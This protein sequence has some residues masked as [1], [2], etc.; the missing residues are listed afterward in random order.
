[1]SR[2]VQGLSI[3][4]KCVH[5]HNSALTQFYR[6]NSHLI[7][8]PGAINTKETKLWHKFEDWTKIWQRLEKYNRMH[9]QEIWWLAVYSPPAEAAPECTRQCRVARWLKY[10]TVCYSLL[11]YNWIQ[12][13]SKDKSVGSSVQIFTIRS[14]ITNN[15][16][17]MVA[18]EMTDD[19]FRCADL[20]KQKDT[21]G[22]LH[23][24]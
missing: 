9:A 2:D 14:S 22:T 11:G 16:V 23:G 10:K 8:Q 13:C 7:E 19:L 12:V 4:Q 6:Q 20:D 21:I 17:G 3:N 24:I 5:W 1:M 18:F 15:Q